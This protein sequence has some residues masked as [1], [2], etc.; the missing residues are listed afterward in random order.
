MNLLAPALS[1]VVGLI[2]GAVLQY[3]F[4]KRLEAARHFQELR[5]R[6]YSDFIAG[7]AG[8]ASAARKRDK[9]LQ[10]EAQAQA[11]EAKIRILLYGSATVVDAV[12]SLSVAQGEV[13]S[14]EIAP[15]F[16]AVIQSMRADSAVSLPAISDHA[17]LSTAFGPE[18]NYAP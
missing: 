15:R 3:H 17:I 1:A 14:M 11:A 4:S 9:T 7:V 5:T 12:A 13:N 2:I 8:S 18:V 16:V 6:A 10:L